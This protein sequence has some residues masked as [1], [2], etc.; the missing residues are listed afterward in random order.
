MLLVLFLNTL[1]HN[2][3][4]MDMDMERDLKKTGGNGKYDMKTSH[5]LYEPIYTKHIHSSHYLI[6]R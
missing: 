2:V 5:I 6:K 1:S 3:I 4:Y